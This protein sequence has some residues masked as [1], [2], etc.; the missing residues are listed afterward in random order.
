MSDS[1][2]ATSPIVRGSMWDSQ[3]QAEELTEVLQ[4]CPGIA[5]LQHLGQ[6]FSQRLWVSPGV[7]YHSSYGKSAVIH[8]AACKYP[9]QQEAISMHSKG[10]FQ[11][12]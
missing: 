10:Q 2:L 12:F 9:T 6:L 5:H 7:T 11:A 8:N 3:P 4:E 1:W